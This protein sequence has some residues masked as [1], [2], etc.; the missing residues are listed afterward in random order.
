MCWRWHTSMDPYWT[1]GAFGCCTVAHPAVTSISTASTNVKLRMLILQ[2]YS[3][4]AAACIY[5]SQ[6]CISSHYPGRGH[7]QS[8]GGVLSS[9]STMAP[10]Q[11]IHERN[12]M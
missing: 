6:E 7:Q 11:M 8:A 3:S 10:L 4:P 5:H 12:E 2:W 9:L 1:P